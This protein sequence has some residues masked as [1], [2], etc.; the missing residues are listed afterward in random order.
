ME[1]KVT[2]KK[3]E[4][5]NTEK[6][7]LKLQYASDL[8]TEFEDKKLRKGQGFRM[9]LTDADV[10]VLAGD[11]G[12]NTRGLQFALEL[13]RTHKK[14][15]LYTLG[16]HEL[17]GQSLNRFGAKLANKLDAEQKDLKEGDPMNASSRMS[18]PDDPRV[19]LL[20]NNELILFGVRFLGTT[21]WTDFQLFGADKASQCQSVA[22][23]GMNDYVRIKLTSG[24]GE[25][26]RR[27]P[28]RPFHTTEKHRQSVE[29]LESR[30][31]ETF[32]GP[33]VVITHHAPHMKS[34]DPKYREDLLSAAYASDLTRFMGDTSSIALWIHGHTHYNCDYQVGKTRVV[35]NARGNPESPASGLPFAADRVITVG[36]C[37]DVVTESAHLEP[38]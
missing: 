13:V 11:I 6:K 22:A 25:Q 8:H 10:I 35:S 9:E 29:W 5:S 19:H 23:K 16:N 31:K 4:K 28:C 18:G 33:T 3:T 36:W 26:Q 27:R 2:E 7:T 20:E 37:N 38:V 17:F 1:V 14:H 21:L 12:N 34:V 30:L 15:V 24:E 32:D